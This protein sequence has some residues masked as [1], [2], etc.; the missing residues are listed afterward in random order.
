VIDLNIEEG[1]FFN[2]NDLERGSPVAVLGHDTADELF[3]VDKAVGQEV[4]VA[5]M[6]MTV[7]GVAAKKKQAFGGG[8]NPEDNFVYMP[9]TTFHKLHPE[10]LDYWIMLK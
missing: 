2:G 6:T 5:G 3:G 10:V 9:V 4:Q 8:K 1:R 7:V